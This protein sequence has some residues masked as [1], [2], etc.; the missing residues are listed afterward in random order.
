[1]GVL[2]VKLNWAC[3]KHNMTITDDYDTDDDDVD[4]D[5]EDDD[6]DDDDED[7][8]ADD[9]DD[10]EN[11]DGMSSAHCSAH[12]S[13]YWPAGKLVTGGCPVWRMSGKVDVCVKCVVQSNDF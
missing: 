5:D 1:M 4:N 3:M 12:W 2:P 10:D 6:A 8:D 7:D 13:R 9:D 11:N